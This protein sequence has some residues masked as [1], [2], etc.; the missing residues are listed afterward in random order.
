M[1][2]TMLASVPFP[3]REGIGFYVWN[4]SRHL[5]HQ[6]HQVQIITRGGAR[7]LT[8]HVIDGIP[9]WR[10]PFL[11]IYPLHVHLHGLFVNRLL[12]VIESGLDIIHAHTPLVKCPRVQLPVV[13][14]VHTSM[15]ADTAAV[16]PDTVLGALVKF[17]APVSMALEQQLL[18]NGG[19]IAAVSASVA[20]ELD[21]YGLSPSEVTVLGNGADTSIFYP[22]GFSGRVHSR[23]FLTA[24]RLAPRKGL[25][26]LIE[27]AVPVIEQH[28]AIQFWIAGSGPM[29]G[30]LR[31]L[32]ARK[33][34]NNTVKLL[35]H[36][37]ERSRMRALYQRSIAYVHPAHYEG[38]PTVLLEAMACGRPVIT[39][40]VSG[41]L[42]VIQHGINGLLTP[43]Q[44]PNTLAKT[45]LAVLDDEAWAVKL[46]TAALHTIQERYAWDNVSRNYAN[47]YEEALGKS[48]A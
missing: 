18:G 48:G 17:Q 40:A 43:P 12:R 11:P 38:L 45:L 23:Y 37:S 44:Q 27:A 29:Y 32:I 1:R 42:D 4:L 8:R 14:T 25:E 3:P 26:D 5:Q 30:R 19:K 15:R 13:A 39:T 2:I 10:P 24:G 34:L 41:S 7:S 9:I 6:G 22:N 47:L 35:G 16:Q 46:G 21:R 36:I 33:N 28:P 31:M 20:Q